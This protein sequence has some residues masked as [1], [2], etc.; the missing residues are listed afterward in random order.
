[1]AGLVVG[2]IAGF[3]AVFAFADVR[4]GD[5]AA[6]GSGRVSAARNP[7]EIPVHDWKSILVRTVREFN[8]DQIPT[9]AAGVTFF[10]LLSLFPALGAFASLYGLFADVGDARR[11]IASLAGLLPGGA[12]TV[13]GDQMTRLAGADHGRLGLAFLVSLILSL[14]ASNAGIK[15]LIAGLNVSYEEVERRRFIRLN[16]VTLS[17]TVG[18]IAFTVLGMAA[19]AAVPA[20]LAGLGIS[21]LNGLSA[22]RWP[23]LLLV[24]IGL[25]SL[26]YRYGPCREHARWR[27]ITPGSV[28]ASIGWMAMSL[29]FSWYVANFGHYDRT[30]GSLG[31]IVGFMTWIWLSLIVV[32]FGAELNA[33]IESQTSVDTTT[34]LARPT[35]ERGAAVADRKG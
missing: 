21:G 20:T 32:L 33:E 24:M 23:V 28:A 19:V 18:A 14:W 22:L 6:K 2:A 4:A 9:V 31:A 26:L 5:A 30:Y 11:Q 16:L 29:G 8:D 10:G 35:G 1:M 13:I 17:F 15:A 34:G 27:W 7:L 25:L 12:L 3:S